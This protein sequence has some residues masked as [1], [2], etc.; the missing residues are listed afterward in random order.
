MDTEKYRKR[1]GTIGRS[2]SGRIISQHT[3]SFSDEALLVQF[4]CLRKKCQNLQFMPDLR[5]VTTT[6]NG[7]WQSLC[8]GNVDDWVGWWAGWPLRCASRFVI[9]AQNA[10]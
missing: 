4:K 1:S 8:C 10:L 5:Y 6:T 2:V 3:I 9:V 7:P